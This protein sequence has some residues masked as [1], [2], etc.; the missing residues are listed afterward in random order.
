MFTKHSARQ[1]L[2]RTVATILI[3]NIVGL[4]VLYVLGVYVFNLNNA[5]DQNQYVLIAKALLYFSAIFYV[6]FHARGMVVPVV[7]G[8]IASGKS[9]VCELLKEQGYQI[10]DADRTYESLL[11][12]PNSY[13]F[14]ML[15]NKYGESIIST[16]ENGNQFIDKMSLK[17]M[18]GDNRNALNDIGQMTQP[19]IILN[20]FIQLWNRSSIL[21]YLSRTP[22]VMEAPLLFETKFFLFITGPIINVSSDDKEAYDRFERR[23]KKNIMDMQNKKTKKKKQKGANGMMMMQNA[24]KVDVGEIKRQFKL[25][26]SAQTTDEVR[27]EG[28]DILIRNDGTKMNLKKEVNKL[29]DVLA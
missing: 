27:N 21:G 3:A 25:M 9:S 13:V 28:S 20:M 12:D 14:S 8:G 11:K 29:I 6:N 23:A 2:F 15:T 17:M 18:I 22:C 10:I 26:K 1:K 16:D 7:T 19:F 24:M 5:N 4:L